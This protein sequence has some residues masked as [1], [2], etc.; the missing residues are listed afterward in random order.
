MS[1]P[2]TSKK[3]NNWKFCE[4]YNKSSDDQ[5]V[6]QTLLPWGVQIIEYNE[7]TPNRRFYRKI[8]LPYLQLTGKYFPASRMIICLVGVS[9]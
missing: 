3:L 5:V 8:F 2:T 7:N 9:L 4:C 1:P 6:N